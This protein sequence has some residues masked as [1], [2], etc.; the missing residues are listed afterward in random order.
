MILLG[1]ITYLALKIKNLDILEGQSDST[2]PDVA[3][4]NNQT[5]FRLFIMRP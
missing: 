3:P 4:N 5:K 2:P 1:F